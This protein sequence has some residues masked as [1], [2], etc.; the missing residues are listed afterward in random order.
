MF[1][2][3]WRRERVL[4]QGQFGKVCLGINLRTGEKMAVKQVPIQSVDYLNMMIGEVTLNCRASFRN[5]NVVSCLG[6]SVSDEH[7]VPG[8]TETAA[9]TG[10]GER[11][12][13][14]V[15]S[16]EALD[17]AAA[18]NRQ[19]NVFLEFCARG[20]VGAQ[21]E[22][23]GT[24]LTEPQVRTYLRQLLMGLRSLHAA[25]I[26]HRD[27]KC[28][29]LLLSEDNVLKLADFGSAKRVSKQTLGP[30]SSIQGSIPW[31]PPEVIRQ[32]VGRDGDEASKLAGWKRAD[33][34][35]VG[36]SMIEMLTGRPP[37]NNYSNPAAMLFAIASSKGPPRLPDENIIHADGLD[38]LH[39]C[40]SVDPTARPAVAKLIYHPY[41]RAENVDAN[42]RYSPQLPA[43]GT[44]LDEDEAQ[45][46]KRRSSEFISRQPAPMTS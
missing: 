28:H 31:M 40:C 26:A 3:P 16:L 12:S 45:P 37:W 46:I 8:A 25:G 35:S 38:F 42:G 39:K 20:S 13:M 41:M 27:I 4:G 44:R 34:W 10:A 36:C 2:D 43:P 33:V 15:S 23:L 24:G 18:V 7:G 32:E 1:C 6:W 9:S 22:R 19:F 17:K 29:N 11:F 5:P 21:L 14:E 30:S